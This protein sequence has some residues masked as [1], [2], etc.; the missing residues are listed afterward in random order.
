VLEAM[1]A[2]LPLVTTTAGAM[3]E[4]LQEGTNALA[5]V[6]VLVFDS[7][8]DAREFADAYRRFQAGKGVGAGEVQL[9]SGATRV[10]V[11]EAPDGATLRALAPAAR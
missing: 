8:A 3:G 10:V 9:T 7:T 11:L 5:L 2:G 4:V 6:W 1:A